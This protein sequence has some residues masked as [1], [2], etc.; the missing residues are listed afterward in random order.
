MYLGSYA[1]EKLK[2]CQMS[3]LIDPSRYELAVRLQNGMPA[4]ITLSSKNDQHNT[5]EIE[6]FLTEIKYHDKYYPEK[7]EIE[8]LTATGMVPSDIKN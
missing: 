8:A 4:D 3:D 1:A 7:I 5:H 2:A 6:T